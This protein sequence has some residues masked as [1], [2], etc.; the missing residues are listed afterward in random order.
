MYPPGL[1][2]SMQ[3][4]QVEYK[5]DDEYGRLIKPCKCRGGLR[6]IHEH[7]LLRSRTETQRVGSMWKCHECGHKFNFKRLTLQKYLGSS[8]SSGV[9]TVLFMI[10]IMFILGFIADPIINLYVDPYDTLVGKEDVWR[11]IEV[12][13]ADDTFTG[14]SLHFMKGLVS[15][16]LVGFLKTAL[17]NP[18]QWWNLRGSGWMTGRMNTSTTTTGRDRAVNISWIAV[19]I[20]VTSAFYFFYQWVQAI[21]QKTLQRIG[22]NIVDTQ[23][24]GDDED[25]KPPAGWKTASE[26]TPIPKGEPTS[27][28]DT[29][30]PHVSEPTRFDHATSSSG[31]QT[32][33]TPE[34]IAAES[35]DDE[36]VL[37]GS[38]PGVSTSPSYSSALHEARDQGWSFA[39]I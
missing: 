24:P 9:L 10:V 16:G 7:C 30:K 14:W 31:T 25:I 23:L 29:S 17:M 12:N 15:M 39:S 22:N 4:P 21:I 27:T 38:W 3:R 2:P 6:Y 11:G 19:V 8:M 28:A 26:P 34:T 36:P 1:P 33:A 32:P 18:F 13:E 20:G 35:L 37:V 5:N